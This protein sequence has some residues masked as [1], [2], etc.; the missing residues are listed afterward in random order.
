M[1]CGKSPS[2]ACLHAPAT[3][4]VWIIS[5][6]ISFVITV[7]ACNRNTP[8]TPEFRDKAL[9]T[10]AELKET[11]TANS[12]FDSNDPT[13]KKSYDSL[14]ALQPVIA[15]GSDLTLFWLL[16]GYSGKI[17]IA[18]AYNS[19]AKLDQI[20]WQELQR[21]LDAC[22]NEIAIVL[23]KVNPVKPLSTRDVCV[24]PVRKMP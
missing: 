14:Q 2:R 21:Q 18:R 1:I 8:V 20:W 12:R 6:F 15:G 17:D 5:C 3:R 7:C 10:F 23:A 13:R 22:Q 24:S 19:N 16:S 9:E 4:L 11:R